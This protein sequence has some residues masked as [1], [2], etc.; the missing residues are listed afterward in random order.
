VGGFYFD[1]SLIKNLASRGVTEVASNFSKVQFKCSELSSGLDT[2][3]WEICVETLQNSED[4]DRTSDAI[5][6]TA[7]TSGSC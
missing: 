6:G 5:P 1:K 4:S 2:C 3:G 7:R